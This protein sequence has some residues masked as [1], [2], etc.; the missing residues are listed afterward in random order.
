MVEVTIMAVAAEMVSHE[1]LLS[2]SG[3]SRTTLLA[4]KLVSSYHCFLFRILAVVVIVK[5][6]V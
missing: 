1:G 6:V 2:V 4:S 5:L 3:T